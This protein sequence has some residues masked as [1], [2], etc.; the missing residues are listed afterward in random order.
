MRDSTD[1]DSEV[2]DQKKKGLLQSLLCN[3]NTRAKLLRAGFYY[4]GLAAVG[5]GAASLWNL[6][7]AACCL[8]VVG[9]GMV[10]DVV[11]L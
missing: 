6:D 4:G 3:A 1:I 7:G 11:K 9:L 8:L 5:A 2:Q 10:Y